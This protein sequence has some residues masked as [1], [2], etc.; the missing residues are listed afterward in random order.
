MK[1]LT[2]M[3]FSDHPESLEKYRMIPADFY[4]AVRKKIPESLKGNRRLPERPGVLPGMVYHATG[5]FYNGKYVDV[6]L[7]DG[8]GNTQF[9]DDSFL[10]YAESMPAMPDFSA[11]NTAVFYT[12][13]EQDKEPDF[14]ERVIISVYNLLYEISCYGSTSLPDR[15][16]LCGIRSTGQIDPEDYVTALSPIQKDEKGTFHITWK[17]VMIPFAMR[18]VCEEIA[19]KQHVNFVMLAAEPIQGMI[20]MN[21]DKERRFLKE[22]WQVNLLCDPGEGDILHPIFTVAGGK[23]YFRFYTEKDMLN[24]FDSFLPGTPKTVKE[25]EEMLND[26]DGDFI[27]I[28]EFTDME[29]FWGDRN[30]K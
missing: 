28:R 11:K 23:K 5:V 22:S 27:E 21:T 15:L 12:T 7:E 18:H 19:K 2:D 1:T 30:G 26:P 24:W 17:T 3:S 25:L 8:N 14:A 13:K 20:Y 10:E 6:I 16:K 4:A 9:I 29:Q